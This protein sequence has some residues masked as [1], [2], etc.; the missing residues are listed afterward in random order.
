MNITDITI[1]N[2]HPK[3]FCF[4]ITDEGEQVFVPPHVA[5]NHN[6]STGDRLPA[7]LVVNPSE[8]QRTNTRWVAVRLRPED[9][10]AEVKVE[11]EAEAEVLVKDA[12]V[13]TAALDA[14]THDLICENSYITTAELA[15]YLDVDTKTAG[16]SAYRLFNSGKIAKA[17]VYARVG[18]SRPSFIMW[19]KNAADFL[20][21]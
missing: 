10:P 19:A 16:N 6:V 20:E 17:D 11:A 13:G 5:D 8:A 2:A 12:P 3:G 1:S 7:Q 4:A 9:K 21:G 15:E 18:L 14:T